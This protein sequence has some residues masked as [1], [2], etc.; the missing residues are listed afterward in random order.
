M[1]ATKPKTKRRTKAQRLKDDGLI[2]GRLSKADESALESLSA[3]EH[4]HLTRILKKVKK[5]LPDGAMRANM[6]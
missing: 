1:A 5:E 6:I 3:E 4:K 2:K